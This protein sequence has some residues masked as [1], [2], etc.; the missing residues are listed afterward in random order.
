M[1]EDF[2]WLEKKG[3]RYRRFVLGIVYEVKVVEIDI[4][5][6]YLLG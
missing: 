3:E 2:M 5:D 6:L 1:C 4:G